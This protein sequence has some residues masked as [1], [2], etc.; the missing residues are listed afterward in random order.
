MPEAR[1]SRPRWQPPMK[2]ETVLI[3]RT[4][5]GA[6]KTAGAAIELGFEAVVSPLARVVYLDADIDLDQFDAVAV[7]SRH[8]ARGLAKAT[9]QRSRPVFAVGDATA[10]SVRR[11]G[12]EDVRSAAGNA[13]ALAGLMAASLPHGASVL[14]ARG[15]LVAGDLKS[16][17][18]ARGFAV[19][20]TILYRTVDTGRLSGEALAALDAPPGPILLVHSPAGGERLVRVL[21]A[22]GIPLEALRA[23]AISQAAAEPLAASGIGRIETASRPDDAH[24]LDAATRL[25]AD[26]TAQ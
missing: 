2:P 13:E 11:N 17:L 15:E 12:F 3:T 9:A 24:L 19:V 10:Q 4:E 22:L 26:P 1:G 25:G 21:T 5:P 18:E 7:T 16:A 20:E 14:H 23:A 6:S 8:G